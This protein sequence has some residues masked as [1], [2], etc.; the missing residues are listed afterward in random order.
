T[1]VPPAPRFPPATIA[2]P[3]VPVPL[4]GAPDPVLVVP[5]PVLPGPVLPGPVLPGPVLPGPVLP[6]VLEVGVLGD[7]ALGVDPGAGVELDALE[8]CAGTPR[9][10]RADP[11]AGAPWPG[12]RAVLDPGPTAAVD[13]AAST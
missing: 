4:P 11:R 8:V 5:G 12:A 2:P 3:L 9:P 13:E 7:G 1:L 6:G 10:A